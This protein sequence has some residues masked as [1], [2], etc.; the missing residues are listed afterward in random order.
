MRVDLVLE[1]CSLATMAGP[2]YGAIEDGLVAVDR[3]RIAWVG[4]RN[5]APRF[6]AAERVDGRGAGGCAG[7]APCGIGVVT[8]W[9]GA[10]P[11]AAAGIGVASGAASPS[12]RASTG[13]AGAGMAGAV[14]MEVM[15]GVGARLKAS[16]SEWCTRV[17]RP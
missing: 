15:V 4:A 13:R 9:P 1:N 10:V 5:A 8:P 2:L 11:W 7:G 14:G 16:G 12:S 3:G 6:E 17:S